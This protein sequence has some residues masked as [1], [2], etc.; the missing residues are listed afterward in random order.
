MP[1]GGY[2]KVKGQ[3]WAIFA[4]TRRSGGE[5]LRVALFDVSQVCR[6][7]GYTRKSGLS[8]SRGVHF[9]KPIIL[10]SDDD[11]DQPRR[12]TL[13]MLSVMPSS[14]RCTRIVLLILVRCLINMALVRCSIRTFCCSTV[15]TSANPHVRAR[16]RFADSFGIGFIVLL[17]LHVGFTYI[18]GMTRT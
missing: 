5:E 17:C 1:L 4:M 16:D 11:V 14:A 7:F 8:A 6:C 3:V 13:P 18:G 9:S 12:P 2:S 15:L 10:A